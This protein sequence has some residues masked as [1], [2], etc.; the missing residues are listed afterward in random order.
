MTVTV[1]DAKMFLQDA[2]KKREHW[3][4]IAERSWQE[5]KKR[6]KGNRLWSVAPNALRKRARYPVW[7]S[8]FKIRKPLCLSRAGTPI[9]RDTTQDGSDNIGATAA[10][11]LERLAINLARETDFFDAISAA[12]DDFLVTDFGDVRMYYEMCEVTEPVKEYI[13]PTKQE[14][15]SIVFLGADGQEIPEAEI[16]Q[17]DEGFFLEHEETIDIENESICIEPLIYKNIYID[18]TI[19][20]FSRAKRIAF[21][22]TYSRDEFKEVFGA[23]AWFKYRSAYIKNAASTNDPANETITVFE[24]WDIFE[25]RCFWFTEYSDEFFEPKAYRIPSNEEFEEMLK[26]YNG[27]YNLSKFFPMPKPMIRNSPTDEFWP[28]PEYY[29]LVDIFEDIHQIFTRMFAVTR[30]IRARLL[31]DANID[32]LQPA[33]NEL[34]DTEAIGIPN[35]SQVLAGNGGSLA[36]ATQYLDIEPL[37]N[38][39]ENLYKALESRLNTV[40]KLSGT[41][42]LLQGLITD[43]TQRTFGERQM[44]EKYAQNQLEEPQRKVAEFVRD[45]Y[46]LMAEMAL[47]NFKDSSLDKYIMPTTLPP[48][49]QERYRAA[50]GLLKDDQ[51]RFRIELETDSTISINEQYDKQVRLELQNALTDNLQKVAQISESSPALVV[52]I[53][54]SMKYLIQG[55]RQGKM[56]Q[57]EITSSIDNNIQMAE[58]AA[59]N[60]PNP[61]NKDEAAAKLKQAE[62]QS[63]VALEQAKMASAERIA[64]R[65]SQLAERMNSLQA[66]LDTYK[67]NSDAAATNAELQLKYAELQST[68]A[69]QQQKFELD[70][71]TLFVEMRKIADK[72]E[73][74][75]FQAMLDAKTAAL[76]QQLALSDQQLR[77]MQLSLDEREKYMTEARLQSEHELEKMR[78]QLEAQAK[79]QE[80]MQGQVVQQQAT[81]PAINI[82]MPPTPKVTR[83][84][85]IKRDEQ[86]N[87]VDITHSETADM[88]IA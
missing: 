32:G 75:Q 19:T 10:M 27:L 3:L 39:L 42:D 76:E 14:D 83:V 81:Q 38:S 70:K 62:I 1:E 65:N 68:L 49:H 57:S 51:K 7:W 69:N 60:N 59:K 35:L 80:I 34:A 43:P 87:I 41:S 15:G 66:Q 9:G 78:A 56:F 21:E 67:I 23:D 40:Y 72:K 13:Q 33:L 29:Q 44:L 64:M 84:S 52:P 11:C 4:T 22:T 18:P 24:Y 85:K 20:R 86:G 28:I 88:P 77:E 2:R 47:R 73:L 12:V 8:I 6:Q 58:K 79:L 74:D 36:N 61:F 50:L 5:I 46:Q 71:E 63:N 30:A 26:D 54:H 17:D 55:M 16:Y 25:K 31:Y 37:V 82:H 45:C 53:L 48:D